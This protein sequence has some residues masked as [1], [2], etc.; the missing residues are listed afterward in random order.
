M[1]YTLAVFCTGLTCLLGLAPALAQDKQPVAAHVAGNVYEPAKLEPTDERLAQLKLPQGFRIARFAELVNPRMIAVAPDGTVYITQ[2]EPGTLTMLR[3][4]DNDGIADVQKV[5]AAKKM[6]HG[7][8]LHHNTMYL[9]TVRS[10]FTAPINADGTL[11]DV[12]LLVDD[13]PDGGQH[14]NRTLGVG[15][16][17]MLYISVGS[18]C[19]ACRETNDEHAALLRLNLQ[20]MRRTIYASGLRNTLGFGWHPASQRLYGVDHGIDWLGDN[21]QQEELNEIVE[22]GRYGWPYVYADGKHV[23]HPQPP[24][25]F[26]KAMWAQ[27][28]KEPAL[29]YTP[30]SAPMQ[31]VFYT[32][33]QFPAEFRN[34]AFVAMR[35]SWNRWPPSGYEVIRVRFDQHGA[36][37]RIEPFVSGFLVAGGAHGPE[38]QF[39][40]LAG[41]AMAKDGALLLSDDTN[42]VVYRV[43]YEPPAQSR[44]VQSTPAPRH[45][46]PRVLTSQLPDM[47]GAAR[48]PV[49]AAAFPPNAPL[50]QVHSAYSQNVSPALTWS[51]IPPQAKSLVVMVE[52]PDATSPKPFVHWLLANVPATVTAL[53]AALP[54]TERLAQLGQAQQGA[55]HTGEIGWSGPKPPAGEPPH[56]YYFQVFALDTT[57]Q[58]PA[59]F[60]RQALLKAMRGHVLAS[61]AVVGTF[62][63][64]QLGEVTSAQQ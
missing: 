7:I 36:P 25:E 3:D 50:P 38:G 11:G 58:L 12:R 14:P 30:H 8:A 40:R 39:A 48:I 24:K 41:L 46:F 4:T 32:G 20:T 16:D 13:L 35:G 51:D 6:L 9:A 1:K 59:G 44:A 37:V 31:M 60:N 61:G 23:A 47:Q 42:G 56:H 33:G 27:M 49:T 64:E 28:S 52:D 54:N 62:Q 26:T 5:V 34:D 15:P 17:S 10:V 53:P 19:N 2:R 63:R 45:A 18:S 29:L 55:N 21:E 43:S 57:L 22:G